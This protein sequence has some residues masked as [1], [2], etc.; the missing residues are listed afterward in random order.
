MD[1]I[2]LVSDAQHLSNK[3]MDFAGFI[4]QLSRS[5]LTGVFLESVAAGGFERACAA[6]NINGMLYAEGAVS[7]EVA[8]ME[9]RY[10]DL[11]L[12]P[13]DGELLRGAGCPVVLMPAQFEGLDQLIFM[14]DGRVD[15]MRQFTYL[16]P[17]LKDLP[18]QVMCV[19]EVEEPLR[20]WLGNHYRD[21]VVTMCGEEGLKEVV[22]GK[23]RAFV[24]VS[25]EMGV[26]PVGNQAVFILN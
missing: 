13:A 18:L 10:A 25:E 19:R 17:E 20:G 12:V 6:R 11:V 26:R 15:A 9:S 8:V 4:C 7:R 23:E 14:Y 22:A 16:F 2:L 5:G 3:A 21:V 24:V 1:K